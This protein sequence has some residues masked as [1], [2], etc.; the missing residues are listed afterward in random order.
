M[1]RRPLLFFAP[2]R[3]V[4]RQVLSPALNLGFGPEGEGYVRKLPEGYWD[5]MLAFA[6]RCGFVGDGS[7][8]PQF[9]HVTV[10]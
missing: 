6:A 8:A 4:Q 5:E 3:W 7:G 2:K 1:Y 10:M 9:G